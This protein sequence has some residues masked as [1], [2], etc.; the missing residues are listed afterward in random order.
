MSYVDA[1]YAAALATLFAYA[2]GL[3]LRRRRWERALRMSE[4]PVAEGEGVSPR[5]ERS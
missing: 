3:V 2:V 4:P 5:G 1:G